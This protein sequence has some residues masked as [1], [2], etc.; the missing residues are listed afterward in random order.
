[1]ITQIHPKLSKS[2]TSPPKSTPNHRNHNN[3]HPNQPQITE[4]TRINTR[5]DT[6]SPK[7]TKSQP[8]STPNHRNHKNHHP[9]RGG[10][11]LVF[12]CFFRKTHTFIFT[13]SLFQA[14]DLVRSPSHVQKG[15]DKILSRGR[16]RRVY[17]QQV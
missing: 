3:H 15:H 12:R 11:Y 4:I 2:I 5:I 16:F 10:G 13:F 14:I 6:K 1:M 17:G 9:N 7:S 8:K